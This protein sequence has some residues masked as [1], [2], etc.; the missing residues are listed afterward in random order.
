M[1]V[2]CFGSG[3]AGLS[4]HASMH[5]PPLL[6]SLTQAISTLPTILSVFSSRTGSWRFWSHADIFLGSMSCWTPTHWNFASSLL[7]VH[8][9][10]KTEL[11]FPTQDLHCLFLSSLGR[12][13]S[14]RIGIFL[15]SSWNSELRAVRFHPWF[16]E[17]I[18]SRPQLYV[19]LTDRYGCVISVILMLIL[20]L[21]FFPHV[22]CLFGTV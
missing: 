22:Y 15:V 5:T 17:K 2:N 14:S 13:A 6:T 21:W 4:V 1:A 3:L 18:H 9:R 12:I 19:L 8:P 20:E 11:F 7:S 16:P 10:T